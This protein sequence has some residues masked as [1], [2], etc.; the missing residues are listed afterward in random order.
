MNT[1]TTLS[2]MFSSG[3]CNYSGPQMSFYR[4]TQAPSTPSIVA[5]TSSVNLC[6]ANPIALQ[7]TA[8][9]DGLSGV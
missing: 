5:P 8:S 1:I 4:D 2:S 6:S 3:S 9:S 7:W